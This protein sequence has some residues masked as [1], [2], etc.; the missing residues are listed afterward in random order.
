MGIYKHPTKK[1]RAI[2]CCKNYGIFASTKM[3]HLRQFLLVPKDS[4][5]GPYYTLMN[6]GF[7]RI[8]LCLT[9]LSYHSGFGSYGP[10][11]VLCFFTISGFVNN[12][13][14]SFKYAD[15]YADFFRARA[16][17]LLPDYLACAF[18]SFL[19]LFLARSSNP[20]Y[21]VKL[22]SQSANFF[23]SSSFWHTFQSFLPKVYIDVF[24]FSL[25][26]ESPLVPLFWSVYC[27]ISFYL[28]LVFLHKFRLV[29][30]KTILILTVASI[31]LIL[32]S[33]NWSG[34]NL[35][36]WNKYIYF[37]AVS[38]FGFFLI[39]V[40]ASL[41]EYH[42]NY[43]SYFSQIGIFLILL[44]LFFGYQVLPRPENLVRFNSSISLTLVSLFICTLVAIYLA[45][46]F[47]KTKFYKH[48]NL[49]KEFAYHSYGIYIWQS[50]V[51][52]F[53]DYLHFYHNYDL[54]DYTNFYLTF[55]T[56]FSLS[57]LF[58]VSLKKFK[59]IFN[60]FFRKLKFDPA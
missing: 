1:S 6:L 42:G 33:A 39:G 38:G 44:Y 7:L 23:M 40:A 55:L 25:N 18:L 22:R 5:H 31:L 35:S 59:E 4:S 21:I 27:E 60:S 29:K 15:S 46:N 54:I 52:L 32:L 2:P 30:Y 41:I 43:L 14:L 3:R 19:I 37:N 12:R 34:T 9:V 26:F 47:P 8:M 58:S 11:A 28:I 53:F 10:L 17:R 20:S 50:I 24:P 56:I 51:F 57:V 48:S 45:C 36:N 16:K 13:S 49:E